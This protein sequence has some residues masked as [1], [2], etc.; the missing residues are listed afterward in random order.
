VLVVATN[1]QVPAAAAAAAAAADKAA[2][3]AGVPGQEAMCNVEGIG[4]AY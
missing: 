2:D 4:M 1:A 3:K